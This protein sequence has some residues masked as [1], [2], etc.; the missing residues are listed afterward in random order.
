MELYHRKGRYPFLEIH[1][2]GSDLEAIAQTALSNSQSQRSIRSH[3][4]NYITPAN[5]MLKLIRCRCKGKVSGLEFCS[6]TGS[7]GVSE[8]YDTR[9]IGVGLG[10][11]SQ[12]ALEHSYQT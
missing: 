4:R 5:A 9:L 12:T 2:Y 10:Q 1:P 6:S 11:S 3:D 8:V 7:N